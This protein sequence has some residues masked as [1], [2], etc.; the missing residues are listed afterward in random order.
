MEMLLSCWFPAL[1]KAAI[2]DCQ[3]CFLKNDSI[4]NLKRKQMREVCN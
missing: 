3:V 2:A 1:L 4:K